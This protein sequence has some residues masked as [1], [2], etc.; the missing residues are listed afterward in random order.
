[1]WRG[2][3]HEPPRIDA[4]LPPD[5]ERGV[6]LSFAEPALPVFASRLCALALCDG[7]GLF[8]NLVS[9]VATASGFLLPAADVDS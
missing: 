8:D 3:I 5:L 4:V 6:D 9:S 1:L 2:E 7:V